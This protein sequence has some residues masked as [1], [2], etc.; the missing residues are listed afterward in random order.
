MKEKRVRTF[1]PLLF[2][3]L[4]AALPAFLAA[5]FPVDFVG[6]RAIADLTLG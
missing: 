6:E 5:P 4:L 2:K 3:V 1:S